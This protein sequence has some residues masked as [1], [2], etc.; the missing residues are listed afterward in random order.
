MT[1]IQI[2]DQVFT[3]LQRAAA[4]LHEPSPNKVLRRILLADPILASLPD[5]PW[6]S[7]TSF[8][9]A[10]P[11]ESEATEKA[12][13]RP[14]RIALGTIPPPRFERAPEPPP[15]LPT[16]QSLGEVLA[17][18]RTTVSA[19]SGSLPPGLR[20]ALDV[21][22]L[23][24][25]HRVPRP[26]AIRRV[27]DLRRAA[28]APSDGPRLTVNSKEFDRML[29]QRGRTDLRAM[30]KG[31]FPGYDAPIDGFFDELSASR[32]KTVASV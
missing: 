25:R 28:G 30:L 23:I 6:P 20:Q 24:V 3:T 4:H 19:H 11:A 22:H 13:A 10:A 9:P 2:D 21:V 14:E 18:R 31:T 1:T 32:K 17:P 26:E 7:V 8:L 16:W 29:R 12:P 5:G 15:R 27:E